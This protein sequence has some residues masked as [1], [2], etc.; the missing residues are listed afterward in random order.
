MAILGG[1]AGGTFKYFNGTEEE[2]YTYYNPPLLLKHK[3]QGLDLDIEKSVLIFVPLRLPNALHRDI[4]PKL[5]LTLS[6]LSS[7]LLPPSSDFEEQNPSGFSHHDLDSPRLRYKI[8]FM[9]QCPVLRTF[10]K[11]PPTY[12]RV[13]EEGKW[14]PERVCLIVLN[15]TEEEM[16][17]VCWVCWMGIL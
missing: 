8:D 17:G 2:F 5:I 16:E 10:P 9:V 7:A 15:R 3:L 11:G 14:R 13:I 12:E 6:P 4:G 1:S